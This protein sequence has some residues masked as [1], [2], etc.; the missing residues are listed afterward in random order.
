MFKRELVAGFLTVILS[1][2]TT[3]NPIWTRPFVVPGDDEYL[4]NRELINEHVDM[5]QQMD[6][7]RNFDAKRSGVRSDLFT[8]SWRTLRERSSPPDVLQ[9]KRIW[10]P[11]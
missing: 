10:V 3:P 4:H 7:M 11:D 2:C 6:W 5:R 1:G 8:Q 9:Q